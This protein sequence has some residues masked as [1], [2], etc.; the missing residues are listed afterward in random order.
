MHAHLTGSNYCL[1]LSMLE[2]EAIRQLQK[3]M[4]EG[5]VYCQWIVLI[6]VGVAGAGK[7]SF[8]K[9]LLKQSRQSV[10]NQN[11]EQKGKEHEKRTSTPLACRSVRVV[12]SE[13]EHGSVWKEEDFDELIR[14]AVSMQPLSVQTDTDKASTKKSSV[15]SSDESPGDITSKAGDEGSHDK[16]D[17][18]DTIRGEADKVSV[19][20]SNETH[21]EGQ[22][23]SSAVQLQRSDKVKILL[24]HIQRQITSCRGQ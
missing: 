7:S 1:M 2:F 8:F 23:S 22:T 17:T 18:S 9:Q 6:L 15:V 3:A 20:S 5:V 16:T 21:D 12:P 24:E 4:D 13:G 19:D 11:K 14:E 10:Y